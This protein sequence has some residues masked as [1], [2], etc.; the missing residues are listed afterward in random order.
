MSMTNRTNESAS[1]AEA[2]THLPAPRRTAEKKLERLTLARLPLT[3]EQLESVAGGAIITT[4][5][6]STNIEP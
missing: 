4:N 6:W 2:T 1:S 5:V 3:L